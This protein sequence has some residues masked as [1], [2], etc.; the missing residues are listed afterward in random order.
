MQNLKRNWLVQNWHEEFN[1]FWPKHSKISKI[2]TLMGCFWPKYIMLQLRKYK[3][4]M[5]DG[6]LDWRKIFEG[7]LICCFKND[8]NLVDFDPNTQKSQKF[9][10][11]YV[12]SCNLWSKNTQRSIFHDTREW[13][14]IWRKSDFCF[15]KWHEEFQKFSPEHL[16]NSKLGLSWDSF[17]QS[18]KCMSLRFTG[19]LC[20]M[21]VKNAAKIEEE[22]TSQVKTDM[23]NLINFDSNTKKSQKFV[24]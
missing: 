14:K 21:R 13:C 8:K 23:S 3:K 6:T 20:A 7:K 4:V 17:V 15:Q 24:L 19:E 1:K 9:A 5:F 2:C 11:W 18:W 10:L 12:L 22:S 16:K